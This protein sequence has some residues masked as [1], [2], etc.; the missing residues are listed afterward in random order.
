MAKIKKDQK[1]EELID[2]NRLFY[3]KEKA[4]KV[5]LFMLEE[6]DSVLEQNSPQVE[7]TRWVIMENIK[8]INEGY[9]NV[10]R[11]IQKHGTLKMSEIKKIARF[12][13]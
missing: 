5:H 13:F 8:T 1:D 3:M 4:L 12:D 9:L 6:L 11:I 2:A 7:H 10:L